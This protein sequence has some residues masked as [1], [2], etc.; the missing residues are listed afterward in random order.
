VS[1]AQQANYKAFD[2]SFRS[3]FNSFFSQ[4]EIKSALLQSL[5]LTFLNVSLRVLREKAFHD[6]FIMQDDIE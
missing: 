3:D 4:P 6:D 2:A 5:H 1:T